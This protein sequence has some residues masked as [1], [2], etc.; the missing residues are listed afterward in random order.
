MQ[1]PSRDL[2]ASTRRL[3]SR[4]GPAA[5]LLAALALAA[6]GAVFGLGENTATL[7]G[8]AVTCG[9]PW[10]PD[11]AAAAALDRATSPTVPGLSDTAVRACEQVNDREA[12]LADA[13]TPGGVLVALTVAGARLME[14]R[15]RRR[16]A[17]RPA[18]NA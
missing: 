3:R 14:A 5:L 13:A 4:I 9:S 8:V 12:L 1:R 16:T 7:P 18:A 17:R 2:G 15:D 6:Q 10:D 11:L